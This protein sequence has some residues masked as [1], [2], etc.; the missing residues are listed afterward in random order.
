M[1]DHKKI[2]YSIVV[3]TTKQLKET[4]VVAMS[5]TICRIQSHCSRS[6]FSLDCLREKILHPCRHPAKRR[7]DPWV[8]GAVHPTI[9]KPI[10]PEKSKPHAGCIHRSIDEIGQAADLYGKPQTDRPFEDGFG[11]LRHARHNRGSAGDNHSGGKP[12][13]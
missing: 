10:P 7:A 1:E 4:E 12:A 6:I 5:P 13:V 9:E 8:T 2:A 11:R 3:F